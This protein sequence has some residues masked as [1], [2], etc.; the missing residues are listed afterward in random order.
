MN[1]PWIEGDVD[2]LSEADKEFL[3]SVESCIV[4]VVQYAR[5]LCRYVRDTV[6]ENETR[7]RDPDAI[8]E[9]I[10][11]CLDRVSE[12]TTE[13]LFERGGGV[14][15]P[16]VGEIYRSFHDKADLVLKLMEQEGECMNSDFGVECPD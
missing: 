14:M 8:L 11:S 12:L 13:Y 9:D 1:M 10:E 6:A 5:A 3:T 4:R 2:S 16:L 15:P 7:P